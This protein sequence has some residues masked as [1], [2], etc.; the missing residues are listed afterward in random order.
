MQFISCPR[1]YFVKLE[2]LDLNWFH[3]STTQC[4]S[5]LQRFHIPVPIIIQKSF[6]NRGTFLKLKSFEESLVY[7]Y[8]RCSGETS[9][10]QSRPFKVCN[11]KWG[12][13]E[14]SKYSS[15]SMLML[16]WCDQNKKV[17]WLE[18]SD[19]FASKEQRIS[20]AFFHCKFH[21]SPASHFFLMCFITWGAQLTWRTDAG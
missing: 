6:R 7:K 19:S 11:W 20:L 13:G 18:G 14:I 4:L 3:L 9:T 1:R 16:F 5:W 8:T 10:F 21:S 15:C 17:I 12:R 2:K